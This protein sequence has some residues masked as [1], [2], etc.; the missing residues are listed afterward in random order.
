MKKYHLLLLVILT[1]CAS[2]HDGHY[3]KEIGENG[4]V[5]KGKVTKSGIIVSGS[6]VTEMAS[7]YF[8]QLDFTFENTTNKWIKVD[9]INISYENKKLDKLIKVPIG[10]KLSLWGKAAQQ[11]KAIADHNF[12]MVMAGVVGAAAV[13]GGFSQN[14]KTQKASLGLIGA[15]SGA[16][17]YNDIKNKL[18]SLQLSK[19][20][21]ESHLLKVP[22]YIP[23]GLHTKKWI[24]IYLQDP[25]N[26]PYMD[27][28]KISYRI[29]GEKKESILIKL[30]RENTHSKFQY[31]YQNHWKKIHKY[32]KQEEGDYNPY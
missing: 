17:A 27:R 18:N 28:V 24:T 25:Y 2:I 21:P 12:S 13:A 19:I 6:E 32:Q 7:N 16:L 15:S 11:N 22:L 30:R 5:K 31:K 29:N 26:S 4:K 20:V 8:T 9:K 10:E 3:A 23:P 14:I 1:S